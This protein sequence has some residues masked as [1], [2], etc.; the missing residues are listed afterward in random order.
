MHLRIASKD[1]VASIALTTL[2]LGSAAQADLPELFYDDFDDGN[3]DGWVADSPH[4]PVWGAPAVAP[5]PEGFAIWGVGSGYGQDDGLHTHISHSLDLQNVA[6]LAIE[7][8]AI[9][10][11]GWPSSVNLYLW[12]GEDQYR[13]TD[14]G[15]SN[16]RAEFHIL[17]GADY[18]VYPYPI[19]PD[20]YDW[21]D[22]RWERDADGWWSFYLDGTLAMADYVQ[23]DAFTS[24]EWINLQ[25]LRNEAAIE[26][27][28]IRGNVIP[29]PGGV[30][31][32]AL[33]PL[34]VVSRR[35]A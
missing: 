30:S 18:S 4:Y 14:F 20:I 6:E 21:H 31:L 1:Q 26:W 7:M 3:Y 23:H 12:H 24:F 5:S 19:G 16:T 11:P 15:E 8:R 33:I 13:G 22:F 2:L 29:G 35:R 10:G 34:A 27:V 25:P 9:T 32:L 17:E 28:R